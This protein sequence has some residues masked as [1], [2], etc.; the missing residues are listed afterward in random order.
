LRVSSLE[1]GNG[2]WARKAPGDVKNVAEGGS[3]RPN[4]LENEFGI[5]AEGIGQER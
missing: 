4:G 5:K 1:Y 3:P 2:F